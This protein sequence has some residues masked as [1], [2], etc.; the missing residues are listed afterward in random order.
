MWGIVFPMGKKKK[1]QKADK[2][3]KIR[4]KNLERM[5]QLQ[6]EGKACKSKC[7]K[8]FKKCET[9]RCKKCPCSDLLKRPEFQQVTELVA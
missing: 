7:C 4:E 1:Q 3:L 8:K 6:C 5:F 9:K 2:L